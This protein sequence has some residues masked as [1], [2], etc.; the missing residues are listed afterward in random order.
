MSAYDILTE[1]QLELALS[2][3]TTSELLSIIQTT[4]SD[5]LLGVAYKL[6]KTNPPTNEE[7]LAAIAVDPDHINDYEELWTGTD[8]PFFVELF[9]C[10]RIRLDVVQSYIA[11]NETLS[12]DDVIYAMFTYMAKDPSLPQYLELIISAFG[13][14]NLTEEQIEILSSKGGLTSSF[15]NWLQGQVQQIAPTA[16]K[17]AH[18]VLYPAEDFATIPVLTLQVPVNAEQLRTKFVGSL[19]EHSG[20]TLYQSMLTSP[21]WVQNNIAKAVSVNAEAVLNS[22]VLDHWLGPICPD[23]TLHVLSTDDI[24]DDDY[25]YGGRRMLVDTS[26]EY[27]DYTDTYL[28]YWF[29]N[30]CQQCNKWIPF[31]H[32]STRKPRF[33]GGWSGCY[34]SWLCLE[35]EM[36]ALLYQ[37]DEIETGLQFN[38]D[39]GEETVML[40]DEAEFN[41]VLDVYNKEVQLIV[42]FKGLVSIA[43]RTS[44]GKP[45]L[46]VTSKAPPRQT[47]PGV[48]STFSIGEEGE[49]VEEGEEGEES[50]V[51]EEGG[52]IDMSSLSNLLSEGLDTSGGTYVSESSGSW[53]FLTFNP[54]V[55]HYK[56]TEQT[57]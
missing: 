18:V 29:T 42:Y 8:Y 44:S 16:S 37:L 35:K 1:Q 14:D 27:D 3:L 56:Q 11:D 23:I 49:E 2:Q 54:N 45:G 19:G 28:G 55:R 40:A 4:T 24:D 30:Y 36:E 32:W 9:R 7:L 26:Y 43:D 12:F 50:E 51:A 5:K 46:S 22:T 15:L 20:D 41:A 33:K 25:K 21:A 34:C 52:D 47:G 13:R 53:P 48:S 31:L 10:R 57:E 17:P 6:L 38:K 39:K